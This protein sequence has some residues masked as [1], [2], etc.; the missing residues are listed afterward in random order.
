MDQNLARMLKIGGAAALGVAGVAGAGAA[1][2]WYRLFRRPLHKM[3]GE[4]SVVGLDDAVEIRRDRW[5][6]PH[7]RA[8]TKHDLWFGQGF[9]HG[10][11]RLWPLDLYRRAS[12]SEEHT[13]ELQSHGYI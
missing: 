12:R 10:Q 5:G 2:A 13:A 8:R 7:I 4:I 9:C 1:G 11:D 6:V 3:S